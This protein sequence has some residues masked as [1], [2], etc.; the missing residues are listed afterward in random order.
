MSLQM[1]FRVNHYF[2]RT[3]FSDFRPEGAV[4]HWLWDSTKKNQPKNPK[5]FWGVPS[6]S[7]CMKGLL[8]DKDVPFL[9]AW[10]RPNDLANRPG[11]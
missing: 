11:L 10:P 8:S 5:T 9:S 1:N 4:L 2:F 3:L 6:K 7:F